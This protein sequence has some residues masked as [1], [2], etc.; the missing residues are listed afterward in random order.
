MEFAFFLGNYFSIKLGAL[1]SYFNWDY[2]G[3]GTGV[4]SAITALA[5]NANDDDTSG[6]GYYF[7][8][9]GRYLFEAYNLELFLDATVQAVDLE[10]DSETDED[11][12]SHVGSQIGVRYYFE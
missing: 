11:T 6:S 9:G 10:F 12:H 8:L 4:Q 3:S 7:G 2:Q 5:I 1:S